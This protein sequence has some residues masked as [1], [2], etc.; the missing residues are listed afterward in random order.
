MDM[1]IPNLDPASGPLSGRFS[2]YVL[3][4]L[5]AVTPGGGPADAG[6]DEEQEAAH[7]LFES[8][9]PQDPADA[10]L[11]ALAIAAAQSAFDNFARAARPGMSHETV[12]RL[13]GNA[14]AATR[15]YAALR[16]Q[17]RKPP[18]E[19]EQQ[20]RS[21]AAHTQAPV[22]ESAPGAEEV[23]PGYIALAPGAKPIPAMEQFAPRD[24]FGKPIPY[25]R[26]DQMTRA[27]LLAA[28]AWPRDPALEAEALAEEEA[29]IAEQKA[30]DAR[31]AA[32]GKP[33]E[34]PPGSRKP[35][36]GDRI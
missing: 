7:E 13:R 34:T 27:Q 11:A 35:L 25:C 29:M 8:L 3:K 19:P 15:A 20:P 28:I 31:G 24:R 26:T 9:N 12:T 23:P 2:H 10:V 21:A 14:L 36:M 33:G 6:E 18:S 22:P 1:P 5:A 4:K 16:R 32:D 30:L 17:L